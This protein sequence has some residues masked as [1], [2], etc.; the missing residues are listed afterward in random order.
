[1]LDVSIVKALSFTVR[2]L[3][4]FSSVPDLSAHVEMAYCIRPTLLAELGGCLM[5]ECADLLPD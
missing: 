1:M 5:T 4:Y 2:F 3:S